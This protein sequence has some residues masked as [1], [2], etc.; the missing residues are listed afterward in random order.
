MSGGLLL[1]T[2]ALI[3]LVA[4][5]KRFTSRQRDALKASTDV[6]ISAIS[7]AELAYLTDRG[8]LQ[9]DAH[10]KNW[11]DAHTEQNGIQILDINYA[12]IAEAFSLPEG[13]HKDPCDRII[14]ATARIHGLSL[15]T[16]DRKL[17][18]YPFVNT[19]D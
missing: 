7:C 14:A 15:I 1:D 6:Y 19:I 5:S 17:L 9:L 11:F 16:D 8:R 4:E 2:C 18:T 3:W 13:F 10:W 12:T